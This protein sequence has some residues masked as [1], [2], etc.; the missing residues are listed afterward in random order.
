MPIR[1][2]GDSAVILQLEAGMPQ[3]RNEIDAEVNS[4]AIRI[5]EGVRQRR[6]RG[7]R[8]V[9]PTFRSVAVFFDPLATD[10]TTIVEALEER[11]DQRQPREAGRVVE[12]P[13]VYGGDA[14]P[15]LASIANDAG[16]TP[17]AVVARH[18]SRAY[19]VFMLGFLPG[20]PYMAPVDEAIAA[21]RRPAP[22]ARVPAG[23]VGI[24]GQQTG[25]YPRESPGGWQIIGRTPLEL[26]DV[27][28]TPPA[29]L[30][31]G[32]TVRFVPVESDRAEGVW[33]K[34]D[35]TYDGPKP[36]T[37]EVRL[38]A[39]T[40]YESSTHDPSARFITVLRPGLFTTIQDA[41]RWGYQH[42]GV[43]VSGPMDTASHRLANALLEAQ[44]DGLQVFSLIDVFRDRHDTIYGDPIHFAH[45]GQTSDSRGNRLVAAAMADRLASIWSFER[46]CPANT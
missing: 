25:I 15:D 22:R 3:R 5:A 44:A 17:E 20:F 46:T 18:A 10:L 34:P 32:D 33:L 35:T 21:P 19:R 43:P 11:S 45:D 31:P 37:S 9:V 12:V 36:D 28:K 27:G 6:I 38:K 4:R 7:V 26:F 39:D 13:V 29:L 2:A 8:D 16:L 23:S 30:A 24:A 1:E 41:G 42:L 40:T 14:G